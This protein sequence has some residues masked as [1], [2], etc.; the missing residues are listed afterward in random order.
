MF[1][2]SNIQQRNNTNKPPSPMDMSRMTWQ[3]TNTSSFRL[4]LRK[5]KTIPHNPTLC[6]L[7][8][9][10]Q[11][12]LLELFQQEPIRSAQL[13]FKVCK[14]PHR[15]RRCLTLE[16]KYSPLH[17]TLNVSA[18]KQRQ[19]NNCTHAGK[20]SFPLEDC[21]FGSPYLSVKHIMDLTW[22]DADVNWGG[23]S[24]KLSGKYTTHPVN[25]DKTYF[26]VGRVSCGESLFM[27]CLGDVS[28]CGRKAV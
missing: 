8:S 3:D 24:G 12:N 26:K 15:L 20:P 28:V 27:T 23:L 22:Q 18:E 7:M 6:L 14:G 2:I 10:G 13:A 5:L 4:S 1:Y 25:T 9:L 19:Q 11:S 21:C 16:M 17:D